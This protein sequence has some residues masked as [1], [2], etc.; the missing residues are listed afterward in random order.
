METAAS[1]SARA[2]ATA[3]RTMRSRVRPGRGPRGARSVSPHAFTT[4]SGRGRSGAAGSGWSM[5]PIVPPLAALDAT[6]SSA[7]SLHINVYAIRRRSVMIE[8]RELRKVYSGREVLAGVDL[9]VPGGRVLALLGPNG[10][11]KTTT[12]RILAT[13]LRPD[14]GT[15]RIGGHDVVREP[16]AVPRPSGLSRE[17]PGRGAPPPGRGT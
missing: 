15:A 1:P 12:V 10:A 14:C 6:R 16:P 8:A 2:T 5:P 7:Y 11:G 13:L 9:D 4:T 3:A 17:A